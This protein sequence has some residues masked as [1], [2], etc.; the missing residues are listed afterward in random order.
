M[1]LVQIKV[2]TSLA[3]LYLVAS[4]RGLVGVHFQEQQ[5]DAAGGHER[6]MAQDILASAARQ[7]TEYLAFERQA[8]ELALDLGGSAFQRRV[9]AQLGRI[10]Y[11]Q[12]TSYQGIAHKL[13]DA[14]AS[15]AVGNANGKNPLCIIVP[16]HRVIASNGTLGGYSGGLD[17][18]RRLLEHE[19]RGRTLFDGACLQPPG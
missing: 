8:F 6:A 12:T 9:W 17:V 18:K 7:L 10:P 13:G 2:D 16:C 5:V 1:P 3:T 19:A 11:G 14:G 15:R 4:A